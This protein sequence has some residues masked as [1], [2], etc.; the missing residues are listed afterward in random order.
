MADFTFEDI[1]NDMITE[2]HLVD[3]TSTQLYAEDILAQKAQRSFNMIFDKFWIKEYMQWYERTIDGTNGTCT[4]GITD[5]KQYD[6]IRVVFVADSDTEIPELPDALNP[7]NIT[8]TQVLYREA[9][10]DDAQGR[11]KF[12]P[13]T[14]TTSIV[15]QARNHPGQLTSTTNIHLDREAMKL[16]ALWELYEEDG[17]NPSAAA[18]FQS[19]YESRLK[20][21]NKKRA[22]KIPLHP[23]QRG[24]VPTQWYDATYT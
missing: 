5:I 24:G 4:V 17:D 20:Q 11:I 2:M 9:T 21:L 12:W 6:D 14:A 8:G 19:L 1:M 23:R 18:K 16:G 7:F 15:I 13:L 3:G 22:N 10:T